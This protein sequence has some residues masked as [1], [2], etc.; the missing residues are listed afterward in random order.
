MSAFVQQIVEDKKSRIAHTFVVHGNVNDYSDNSGMRGLIHNTFS[1]AFDTYCQK[2]QAEVA[3]ANGQATTKVEGKPKV[4]AFF[5]VNGGL[6]FAHDTGEKL[7]QNMMKEFYPKEIAADETILK[8]DSFHDTLKALNLFFRASKKIVEHNQVAK[9]QN[10]MQKPE[11]VFTMVFYDGDLL[12]P[13]GPISAM[14]ADRQPIG[15]V[16]N[17][18]RDPGV[19]FLNKI[20]IV[21]QNLEDIHSSIRGG[22]SKVSAVLVKKPGLEERETFLKN[23]D[24]IIRKLAASNKHPILGGHKISQVN[25]ANDLSL[26]EFAALAAG[27]SRMQMEG[28]IFKSWVTGT[29]LDPFMIREAKQDACKAEFGNLIEFE[30]AK[31]GFERIGGH[32]HL[33][34]YAVMH[35]IAPL[36]GLNFG[37]NSPQKHLE[38]YLKDSKG[39]WLV[40]IAGL[41]TIQG[42]RS[43]CS[44]GFLMPGPPGTGKSQLAIALAKECGVSFIKLHLDRVFGSLVGETEGNMNRVLQAIWASAPCI[45][46]A[47][48][49]DSVLSAGRQSSGDSG[50]SSR[51]FNSFMQFLSDETRVGKIVVIGATNRPDLLDK[52]LIRQ[53]RFDDIIPALPPQEKDALGRMEII[54]ALK[55]KHKAKLSGE[56]GETVQDE[57]N[58]LGQLL[59]DTRIWTGAEIERT[60]QYAHF[61]SR[62]G[63]R[64]AIGL[65]DWNRAMKAIMPK[66]GD[67][68][69]Q[70][71]LALYFINNLDYC[72]D[73][74]RDRAEK[75]DELKTS[76]KTQHHIAVDDWEDRE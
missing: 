17:W 21:T 10:Q 16:R 57:N 6:E 55:M 71:D 51:V 3:K 32:Q 53:G 13:N 18:A 35:I 52:A 44:R 48:E 49:L 19:G 41:K 29:P 62:A 60:F 33:K 30:Q 26:E 67:V 14:D 28:P 66:T 11:L 68:Q 23:Y 8:P 63:G 50:T 45:V 70:I 31:W 39:E 34:R 59:F 25:L 7:W 47:D 65:G 42:D 5:T 37:P 22:D 40:D 43:L 76:L 20:I 74:W 61:L 4:M 2:A 72:P 12:F 24:T 56:L 58:G 15:Y 75:H 46:F 36:L 9:R 64:K 73:G 69:Q 27:M 1:L 54:E 38:K